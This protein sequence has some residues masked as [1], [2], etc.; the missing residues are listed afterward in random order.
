MYAEKVNVTDPWLFTTMTHL[1]LLLAEGSTPPYTEV[2]HEVG[3]ASPSISVDRLECYMALTYT[4]HVK[5]TK[6]NTTTNQTFSPTSP[7]Y[8]AN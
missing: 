3:V 7:T 4:V 8:Y 1:N 6:F 5:E 2:T